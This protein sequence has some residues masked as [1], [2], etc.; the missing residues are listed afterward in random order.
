MLEWLREIDI[1][2]VP[3]SQNSES[4]SFL[5]DYQALV[6]GLLAFMAAV[7]T[8]SFLYWQRW[9]NLNKKRVALRALLPHWLSLITTYSEKCNNFISHLSDEV[10]A[11]EVSNLELPEFPLSAVERVAELAEF[12][13]RNNSRCLSL[14]VLFAQIQNSR[15]ESLYEKNIKGS[16]RKMN[17]YGSVFDG[18]YLYALAARCYSYGR[19][20]EDHIPEQIMSPEE[21]KK[22]LVFNFRT[23]FEPEVEKIIDRRWVSGHKKYSEQF[24]SK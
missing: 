19:G 20:E 5:Y 18:M 16:H 10:D 8:I 15:L 13:G 4:R 9:D 3:L 1:I 17:L 22:K 12:V 23:P 6:S 2:F 7:L 14:L 24:N 11:G 21:I